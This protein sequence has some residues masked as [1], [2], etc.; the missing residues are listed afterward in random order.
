MSRLL[1]S[2]EID[3]ASKSQP[4][5][6]HWPV[7]LGGYSLLVSPGLKFL[8]Q[9]SIEVIVASRNQLRIDGA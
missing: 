4:K 5:C 2:Q 7:P 3:L 6:E 8:Q 9:C 1:C